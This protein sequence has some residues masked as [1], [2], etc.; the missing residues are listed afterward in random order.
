MTTLVMTEFGR[1]SYENSSLGTDHGRAFSMFVFSDRIEGG[2][3]IG[4]WPGI[5]TEGLETILGPAG[6]SVEIDYRDVLWE[7]VEDILGNPNVDKVFPGFEHVN[8]NL[9]GAS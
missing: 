5:K 7:I 2:R 4:D 6:L 1:R 8:L 3:V 9:V